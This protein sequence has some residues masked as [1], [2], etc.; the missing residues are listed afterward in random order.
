M[1][2]HISEIIADPVSFQNCQLTVEGVCRTACSKPFPH[3]TVEDKTGTLICA[4]DDLLPGIGE[5]IEVAGD[6]IVDVPAACSFEIP[7]LIETSRQVTA[8]HSNCDFVGCQFEVLK[9]AIAA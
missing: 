1:I 5:H 8:P 7:R 6:F 4:T 9:A 3:F 2:T